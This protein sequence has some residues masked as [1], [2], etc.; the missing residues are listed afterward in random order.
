MTEEVKEPQEEQEEE[1]ALV[2]IEHKSLAE[3]L[4]HAQAEYPPL[5]KG[6]TVDA[7][8]FSYMYAD[9]AHTKQAT[10]P[11][12][13]K[14]G[15]VVNS[16]NEHR[17]GQVF[18]VSSLKHI[19]SGEVETSEFDVSEASGSI[20]LIGGNITFARRYN[21]CS[22]TGRIG[23]DSSETR[24]LRRPAASGGANPG[25]EQG[26]ANT[27]APDNSI[28]G[29]KNRLLELE[30]QKKAEGMTQTEITEMRVKILGNMVL[31]HSAEKLTEYGNALAL[32]EVKAKG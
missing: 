1:A 3:A 17:D 22:L 21:Y 24:D 2:I 15:L 28:G 11:Y 27:D 32:H 29:I 31:D 7:G 26:A 12:L 8:S 16:K 19:H 10:D 5:E 4:L 13:W 6:Q 25:R 20:K 30:K 9:L 14:H 18:C 23:E